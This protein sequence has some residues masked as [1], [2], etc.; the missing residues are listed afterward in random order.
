[1]RTVDAVTVDALLHAGEHGWRE[2]VETLP[3]IV[4]IARPDGWHLHYNRQWMDFTGLTLEESLG[5]GWNPPFHPDDRDRARRRW[6]QATATGEP[7][8]IEYR[9]RRHDGVYRWMLGRALPL[10]APDGRI[11]RWFGTCTDIDDLKRTQAELERAR[12]MQ[13]LAGR[14]AG[15]GGWSLEVGADELVWSDEVFDLL[16]LRG[17]TPT[18]REAALRRYDPDDRPR[19][20]AAVVACERDGVPFDLEAELRTSSGA[21][22]TVRVIGEAERDDA[23]QVV[24][25]AGAVQD[26]TVLREA[27]RR[28]RELAERLTATLESLT[29]GFYTL[30]REGRFT[31]VNRQAER[32]LRHDRGELLGR[33]IFDVFPDAV[34]NGFDL[35]C[36]QATTTG[37]PVLL[38]DHHYAPFDTWYQISIAPS[39]QGL[40]VSFRDTTRRHLDQQA[41][42]ERMKELRALAAVSGGA[43]QLTEVEALCELTARALLEAVQDPDR[44]S[45]EVRLGGTTARFGSIE[46][47]G[48]CLTEPI[49]S[50]GREAG[51]VVLCDRVGAPFL[52]E[53]S[54][55]VRAVA[56]TLG[57]WLGRHRASEALERVNTELEDANRQ[58]AEA[59]QLKD[60]LLS[61]ASHEL[62]TPL[63]P[64]LGFLELLERRSDNLT[65]HQRRMVRV[66][67]NNARR[68]LRL[69]DDLLV[70][71]RAAADVLVAQRS[72]VL[73]VH[74]LAP[75]LE[76]LEDSLDSVEVDVGDL[77]VL[78]DLQHLQ[79]IVV[80]LLTNAVK[81]GRP[82]VT[83][84][85]HRLG[86][87]RVRLEVADRGPGVPEAFRTRMWERFEQKDRGDTRTASGTGLGL[88][89]VRL[90]VE[91]NGGSAGYRDGDPH[92]AVF[93]VDLPS[94]CDPPLRQP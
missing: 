44:A 46:A 20:A 38:E 16:E 47:T 63:T 74:A 64:I 79:Q 65:D 83:I 93:T 39:A 59:A 10:R 61:M 15:L 6:E 70:V 28:N 69:V 71:S 78:A 30:D 12:T 87:R 91:A 72:R 57:L 77:A 7:Y 36:R 41:L 62:R 55:L 75:V 80:N 22:R 18:T 84:R 54:D 11:V 56:E 33:R 37:Q 60:D 34:G 21:R 35:A 2:L 86:E 42:T 43:H 88:A 32:L 67:R 90:L 52:R 24:R 23:G 73:L 1:M 68:M 31:Y 89:I 85:A 13:R 92:G 8:E 25:V 48:E 4:W 3:Q 94:A 53:E 26:I 76:E 49:R 45:V 9:L 51:H 81:Y 29:E 27:D 19:I 50:D 17:D 14:M 82:P 40:S 5:H 66:M 58:L